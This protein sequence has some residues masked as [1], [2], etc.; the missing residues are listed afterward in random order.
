MVDDAW[1]HRYGQFQAGLDAYQLFVPCTIPEEISL[2]YV[3][4]ILLLLS[5]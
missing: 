4:A 2:N 5:K 1:F 3:G